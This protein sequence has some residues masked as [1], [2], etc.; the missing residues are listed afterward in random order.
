M[1]HSKARMKAK[2]SSK[3][4]GDKEATT[5]VDIRRCLDSE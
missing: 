5:L 1:V 4:L 2:T 3:T